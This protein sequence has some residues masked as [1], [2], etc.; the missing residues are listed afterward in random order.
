MF[1]LR[2]CPSA[3]RSP[4]APDIGGA[5]RFALTDATSKAGSGRDCT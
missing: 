1:V 3:K 4:G 5:D 2:N